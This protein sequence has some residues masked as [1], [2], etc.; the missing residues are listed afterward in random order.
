[1]KSMRL[2]FSLIA[3][4]CLIWCAT[5][6]WVAVVVLSLDSESALLKVVEANSKQK[7][8]FSRKH[9]VVFG[10]GKVLCGWP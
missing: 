9:C 8:D 3:L 2:E 1:M 5:G 7:V 6:C 10:R 4:E